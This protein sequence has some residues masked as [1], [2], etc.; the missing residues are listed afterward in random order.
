MAYD[1]NNSKN[2]KGRQNIAV[3]GGGVSG[4][5]AALKL[6]CNHNVTIFEVEEKLGGHARTRLAGPN[7]DIAVDTGFMV[8]NTH[9]YPLLID[10]FQEL[11]IP[12]VETSMSFAVSLDEGKFEYGLSNIERIL[13]NPSNAL[14]PKFLGMIRDILK[15]N[16]TAPQTSQA[17][18]LTLKELLDE[19]G[20]GEYFRQRYLYPLSGAIWSTARHDMENFPAK[21]FV[22]FFEN[23]GLL[24]AHNG[25]KWR[26]IVGGSQVYVEKFSE[27]P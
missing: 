5:G 18:E 24:S 23:H 13:A 16:K 15:F 8:F 25:P 12:S 4:L 27:H 11:D 21:S 14:S 19:I 6:S 9:T 26:T 1:A 10:L 2:K 22:R 17:N 7:K 3:I 20:V